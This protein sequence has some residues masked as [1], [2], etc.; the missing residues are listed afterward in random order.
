MNENNTYNVVVAKGTEK[1]SIYIDAK[2]SDLAAQYALDKFY[3]DGW[4]LVSS[5]LKK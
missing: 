3:F 2:T 5:E 4:H 1:E